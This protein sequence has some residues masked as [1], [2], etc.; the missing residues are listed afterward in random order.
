VG[1][2]RIKAVAAKEIK[3]AATMLADVKRLAAVR[4]KVV[5]AKGIKVTDCTEYL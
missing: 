5:A 2:A 3:V 1:L 4:I